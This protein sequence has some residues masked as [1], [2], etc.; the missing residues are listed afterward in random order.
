MSN[1]QTPY[2]KDSEQEVLNKSFDPDFKVLAVEALEFDGSNLVRKPSS[3]LTKPY[4]TAVITYTD[5]TKATIS[6][7]VTKLGGVTQETLTLT[8]GSTTDTWARS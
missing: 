5:S 8:T 3:F 7:V 2:I 6:T 4:D 1:P